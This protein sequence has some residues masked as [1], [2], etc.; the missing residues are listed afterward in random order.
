MGQLVGDPSGRVGAKRL[1]G[2]L[3]QGRFVVGVADHAIQFGLLA[4]FLRRLQL[5]RLVAADSAASSIARSASVLLDASGLSSCRLTKSARA[6]RWVC[7]NGHVSPCLPKAVAFERDDQRPTAA[8]FRQAG[9]S[10]LG[11]RIATFRT[12]GGKFR[13][14]ALLHFALSATGLCS[15]PGIPSKETPKR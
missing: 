6:S 8:L 3:D 12:F 11:A 1:V 2:H 5:E 15:S 14:P 9:S 10:S 7:T 4:S 13:I